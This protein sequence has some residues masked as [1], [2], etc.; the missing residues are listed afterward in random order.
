MQRPAHQGILERAHE[1]HRAEQRE[2]AGRRAGVGR[3]ER[4]L[5]LSKRSP[6]LSA[7][8]IGK[9]ATRSPTGLRPLRPGAATYDEERPISSAS[10]PRTS[11]LRAPV[12]RDP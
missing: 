3:Q 12:Q 7:R 8:S 1:Q 9:A 11:A 10:P 4:L 2:Q 6:S 5:F